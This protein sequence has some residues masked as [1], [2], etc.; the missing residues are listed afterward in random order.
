M[1]R[2]RAPGVNL[3]GAESAGGPA[4]HGCRPEPGAGRHGLAGP[5]P[6]GQAAARAGRRTTVQ[7]RANTPRSASGMPPGTAA[8]R[9]FLATRQPLDRV[10]GAGSVQVAEHELCDASGL[11]AA[12]VFHYCVEPA[13]PAMLRARPGSAIFLLGTLCGIPPVHACDGL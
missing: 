9:A 1:I 7:A 3:K 5:K 12:L 4:A 11:V 6:A 2:G 8:R 10:H 13:P